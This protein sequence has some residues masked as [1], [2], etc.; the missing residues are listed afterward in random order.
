MVK[1]VSL[2][3]WVLV[4]VIAAASGLSE[5][6]GSAARGELLD[7]GVFRDAGNALISGA[8]LY[9]DFPTRSGF[10]FIYPPFAALLFVPLTWMPEPV[11]DVV[12]TLATMACV[13]LISWL[14]LRR[15]DVKITPLVLVGVIAW[16]LAIDPLQAN[17]FFG[18]INVFLFT[19]VVVDVLGLLP[20][21]LRG[22]GVGIAAGIKITPAAF[23]I[24]FLV[25]K[26][27]ASVARAAGTFVGTI[28]IGVLMRPAETWY[29]FTDEF[30]NTDRG[31]NAMY[32]PNQALSGLFAR[33]GLEAPTGVIFLV[34]ALL[35]GLGAWYL[36]RRGLDVHALFFVALG[37][38]VGGPYAVSHHFSCVMLAVPLIF[39][40]VPSVWKLAYVLYVA[41]LFVPSYQLYPEVDAYS[42]STPL[43]YMGN[44]MGSASLTMWVALL[45][46][47]WFPAESKLIAHQN[48]PS[49]SGT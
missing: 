23:A 14:A 20:R 46:E 7:V 45:L 44:L 34:F 31:G 35:T 32:P 3:V 26:D 8:D 42:F 37:I 47:R 19:L 30:F 9:D 1:Q 11:M 22:V 2:W 18:Q 41:V 28:L 36:L 29:Y 40:A 39:A 49:Y 38:S 43:W 48:V 33:A 16:S 5:V 12:W 25:K 15:L 21:Q 10:R 4:G 24:L 13:A 27:W 6:F 17:F